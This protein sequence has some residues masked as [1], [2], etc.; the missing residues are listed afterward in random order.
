VPRADIAQVINP[1]RAHRDTWQISRRR[2][3][4]YE[5]DLAARRHAE[6]PLGEALRHLLYLFGKNEA[7]KLILRQGSEN[8]TFAQR[9]SS[10][11][12]VTNYVLENCHEASARIAFA[13]NTE[14][15]CNITKRFKIYSGIPSLSTIVAMKPEHHQCSLIRRPVKSVRTLNRG[16]I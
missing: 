16:H 11:S 10:C 15:L 9:L 14:L 1:H 4:Q 8:P 5:A 13:N 12:R 3:Q 2:T 7:I 6:M